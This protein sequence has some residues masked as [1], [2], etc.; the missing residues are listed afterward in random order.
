[1]RKMSLEHCVNFRLKMRLYLHYS[2]ILE[3]KMLYLRKM[4]W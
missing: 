4:V 1:M 3:N 2:T